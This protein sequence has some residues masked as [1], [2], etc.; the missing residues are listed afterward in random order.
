MDLPE[1]FTES[2]KAY[3]GDEYEAFIASYNEK[4][5]SA[6]RINTSKITPDDFV[7]KAPY[8]IEKIPFAPNAWS[9]DD[10]DAWS[11]HPYYYAGLYYLQEPSAMLP[12]LTLPIESSDFVLDL[13]AA[14][15]GKSTAIAAYSPKVL[16]S[17]DISPSRAIPLVR[18]LEHTGYGNFL[19]T[20]E[21][22]SKLKDLYPR[23]FDKILVDAPCSGEGMFRKDVHLI[24]SYL[25]KGP[26]Y[27]STLQLSIL[28]SAYEML[29]C[30]GKMLYSTCTFSDIEDEQVIL[31]FIRE[32]ADMKVL[33]IKKDYGLLGPYGK[34]DDEKSIAG[35]VHAFPHR[36]CGEGHF[37]ALLQKDG[38]VNDGHFQ[39]NNAKELLRYEALCDSVKEYTVR[40]ADECLEKIKNSRFLVKENA[41][42]MFS[43]N[44]IAFYDKN[45]RY[46]RTGLCLGTLNRSGKFTPS[47]A[48]ALSLKS[49]DHGNVLSLAS[50]DPDIIRY[51]RGETIVFDPDKRGRFMPQK[52]S[53]LM[54]V[55]AYPLGFASFDGTRLKNQY[56]KGWTY[57]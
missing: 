8:K 46:A 22:P 14:P 45:V 18:N 21:D 4:P 20:A 44:V 50:D 53:V 13:C 1:V 3:L 15:G 10:T 54:C 12:A 7:K 55:D 19:V 9:I 26:T 38:I 57:R 23:R 39:V 35:V 47:T 34:Y 30:G 27:Y 37:M 31:S 33:D 56:E 2:V 43:E 17:N 40:L 36:F 49:S 11:K 52:G 41:I 28:K 48:F 51:L 16:V 6:L 32:H 29:K 24:A 5:R 25:E 42:Y